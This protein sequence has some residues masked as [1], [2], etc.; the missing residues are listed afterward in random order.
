MRITEIYLRLPEPWMWYGSLLYTE[1]YQVA[2][3]RHSAW[4]LTASLSGEFRFRT[5]EKEV[6][7]PPGGWILMSPEFLHDAGSDSPRSRAMQIF[8]RRFPPDLLPELAERFNLRRGILRTGRM[9]PEFAAG[10][11]DK[12]L[13]NAGDEEPLKKSWRNVL[14]LEFIISALSNASAEP[15]EAD[16]VHPEIVR[17]LEFMEEHFT[18]PLG[19][20]EFARV[21]GLSESRFAA[22]FKQETG[23]T[24]MHFFNTVRLGRAQSLLLNGASVDETAEQAGFSST[25]YFC[26]CFK[27]NTGVSPGTF[28]DNP[29]R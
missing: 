3:H 17:V 26:R 28:R 24:P 9:E 27:K 19:V 11:A 7:L 14:G 21:A 23:T 2:M 12:F 15:E 10:I 29:F 20:T 1:P 25:Q 8:F 22:V 6:I 13:T 5:P 18:E 16:S 4:Q